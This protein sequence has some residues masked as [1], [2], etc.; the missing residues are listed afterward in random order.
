MSIL[1]FSSFSNLSFL[2]GAGG[3]GTLCGPLPLSL[4]RGL[5]CSHK[6][7]KPQHSTSLSQCDLTESK[8]L[9]LTFPKEWLKRFPLA[10]LRSP[11]PQYTEIRKLYA[12]KRVKREERRRAGLPSGIELGDDEAERESCWVK[13]GRDAPTVS[14]WD[15]DNLLEDDGTVSRGGA[16]ISS[17]AIVCVVFFEER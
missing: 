1:I 3:T 11:R 14:E 10:V 15:D 7:S 17:D 9:L 5:A 6:H 4:F 2:G 13:R 8:S 16:P 12:V